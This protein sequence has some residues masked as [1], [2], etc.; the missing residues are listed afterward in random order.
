[1]AVHY[2]AVETLSAIIGWT[3]MLCWT[4]SFYP[5]FILNLRRKTTR[6]YSIDFVLLNILGMASY[7]IHNVVMFSSEV[8]RAQY[9]S[10]H[11]HNPV[12]TVRPNDVAYAVH[13]AVITVVLFSQFYPKVWRF[14]P[15][16]GL[17]CS[18]WAL[19]IVWGCS[20]GVVL[21]ALLVVARPSSP[22]WEWL[23]VVGHFPSLFQ[24]LTLVCDGG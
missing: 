17:R 24:N 14:T 11:P 8:V 15:I 5:Q 13:G 4:V 23:D 7:A 18:R 2:D 3:Y 22:N 19:G 12:P 16:E 9:A 21:A 1:M 20:I 6:G 10:R